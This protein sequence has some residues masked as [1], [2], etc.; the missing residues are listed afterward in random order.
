MT[1]A[2]HWL[3]SWCTSVC[4]VIR[5]SLSC[6]AVRTIIVITSLF[7]LSSCAKENT[8]DPKLKNKQDALAYVDSLKASDLIVNRKEQAQLFKNYLSHYYSPWSGQHQFFSIAQL[9][10]FISKDIENY[11][12]DSGWGENHQKISPSYI[13]SLVKN[14]DLHAFPNSNQKAIIVNA[15]NLRKFPTN[16]PSYTS[17]TEPGWFYPFD[18][19]QESY[20]PVNLPV[21]ILQVSKDKAWDYVVASDE[22]GWVSANDVAIIS[23]D[24]I[25][26]WRNNKGYINF[27]KD[28]TA[29][30]DV[31]GAYR[32]QSHMGAIY[33]IYKITDN[34]YEIKF[35]VKDLSG[36]AVIRF[37][38]VTKKSAYQIPLF[39]TQK[40]IA[41][42][43]NQFVDMPYGWGGIYGYRDCSATTM[44]IMS[45]FG[46][47]LPRA[48]ATQG[49]G[50][51][52]SIDLTT[53]SDAQKKQEISRYAIP[54]FS[55]VHLPGH[56]MLYLGQKG[57]TFYV[58]HN[59]WSLKTIRPFQSLG[60]AVI[61]KTIITP[62][63]FG[64]SYFNVKENLLSR[65]T[66]ITN[67]GVS[68]PSPRMAKPEILSNS[69]QLIVVTT[70]H[71]SSSQG[72]L[73]RYQ[74][75]DVSRRWRSVGKIIPIVLGK[76]GLAWSVE[77]RKYNISSNYKIEGDNKSPAGVFTLG[78]AFGFKAIQ[79]A[80][81]KNNFVE[82]KPNT[83]CVDAPGSKY[84]GDIVN[85]KNSEPSE[86]IHGE[87][88]SQYRH[89]YEYGL[90]VNYNN[91]S[92]KTP[93]AG[94]CIFMHVWEAS[95]IPTVGCT[96][97]PKNA[98][99]AI[100]DWLRPE[101]RP[102]LVQLSRQ[103]YSKLESGWGLPKLQVNV[104]LSAEHN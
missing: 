6:T 86:W 96:A 46:V 89:S 59:F 36:K 62:I 5:A 100:L 30:Y 50:D 28:D 60:R 13:E 24:V 54:Y 52:Q 48:S 98:M 79:S 68:D 103:Q 95:D 104:L 45:F 33:P 78:T 88:M 31:N 8:F 41:V 72:F 65:A 102:V 92:G 73:Q 94:S 70:S 71:L 38:D 55:L 81:T 80:Y 20:F 66:S 10:S 83:I 87:R 84:Y 19:F 53:L 7:L 64:R 99:L 4:S 35:A 12:N 25:K 27:K 2:F 49:Q 75:D 69:K 57:S 44:D 93:G 32:F 15:T 47:W 16:V 17:V 91:Q 63:D 67:L 51:G 85:S 39:I 18:N 43:A 58:L 61:G 90:L 3:A 101:D 37:A 42:I 22:V 11:R 26:N 76:N 1:V 77:Y 21:L 82:I 40:N 97:M 9:K 34:S 29:I 56:V 14:I 23:P 74:R